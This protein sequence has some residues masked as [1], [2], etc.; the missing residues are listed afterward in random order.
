MTNTKIGKKNLL[1]MKDLI[2]ICTRLL[3]PMQLVK[4]RFINGEIAKDMARE[5]KKLAIPKTR[6]SIM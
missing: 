3:K 5:I 1:F 2:G 4:I 6:L